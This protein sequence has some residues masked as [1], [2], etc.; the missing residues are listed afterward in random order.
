MMV[1]M[2]VPP[3]LE[4]DMRVYMLEEVPS[5]NDLLVATQVQIHMV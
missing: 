5:V 2:L 3:I 1:S 4:M